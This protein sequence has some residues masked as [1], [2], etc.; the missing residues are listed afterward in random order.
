MTSVPNASHAYASAGN[1]NVTVTVR[2][3]TNATGTGPAQTV[4]VKTNWAPHA[5]FAVTPQ[6][7]T[8]GTSMT[9]DGSTTTDSDSVVASYHWDFGDGT[10]A[11][12]P[13]PTTTHSYSADGTYSATLDRDRR[14]GDLDAGRA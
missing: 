8:S 12:T 1:Y 4:G 7:A 10:T 9:F 5:H 3:T 6:C 11:D 14:G 13:T 2:D